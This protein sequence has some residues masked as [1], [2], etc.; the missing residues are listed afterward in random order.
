ME[1]QPPQTRFVAWV[2]WAAIL[3]GL[4]VLQFVIGGGLP[5]GEDQG[6][7]SIVLSILPLCALL[8]ATVIRWVV[9]PRV[10]GEQQQLTMM[11]IGV[12]LAE[13]AQII[14]L[15]VIGSDFPETQR[16]FLILSVIGVLQFA[17]TYVRSS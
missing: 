15:F 11:I 8:V 12:A 14:Q 6:D 1:N 17:P 9:I 4:F 5:L 10:T 2:I 13:S 3:F 16:A 7:V